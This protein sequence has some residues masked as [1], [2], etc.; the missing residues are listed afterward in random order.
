MWKKIATGVGTVLA[1]VVL[2]LV[3]AALVYRQELT[4]L[5]A[6]VQMF[7]PENLTHT[8]Q[9][10]YRIQ[11]A[12]AIPA[13][14]SVFEFDRA[15]APLPAAFVSGERELDLAQFL[16]ERATMGL[17]VIQND[18]ILHESYQRGSSDQS[19][20]ASN[21]MGK[22]FVSALAGIALS[23]GKI[24]SFDDNV[25]DYVAELKGSEW[26]G[27]TIRQVAT[28]SSGMKFNENYADPASDVAKMSLKMAF[29]TPLI[30]YLP[31]L[32]RERPA[33]EYN[34]YKSVNSEVLGLVVERAIGGQLSGYMAEKLWGPIGAEREAHWLVEASEASGHRELAMGGLSVHLRDYARFGRLY[35]HGGNWN[36]EQIIPAHYVAESTT[37]QGPHLAPGYDN[38]GSSSFSGYGYQWWIPLGSQGDFQ[39]QGI[40]G[41]FIYV[42]PATETVI[43]T[44]RADTGYYDPGRQSLLDST[45]MF[46]AIAA[47]YAHYAQDRPGSMAARLSE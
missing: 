33:G 18:V 4:N 12:R 45:A 23:E 9:N 41:Q 17:L 22:S 13:T 30:E 6:M 40:Y 34:D 3:S 35:L 5:H 20:F 42:D 19:L 2:V 38:P 10:T 29:G 11:P 27:V 39:A 36:G 16:D 44:T 21:S 28:M 26:D 7:K 46:R 32:V 15:E 14:G 24:R 8:F 37:V 47:H 25:A 1:V 31:S 43:V